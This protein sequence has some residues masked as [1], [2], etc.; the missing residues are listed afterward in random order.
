MLGWMVFSGAVWIVYMERCMN[1]DVYNIDV[2]LVPMC[3]FM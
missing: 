3:T 1:T 2:E